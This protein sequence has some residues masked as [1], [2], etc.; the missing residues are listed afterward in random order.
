MLN[1]KP[2]IMVNLHS[3]D[4]AVIRSPKKRRGPKPK[5]IYERILSQRELKPIRKTERTYSQSQK[6]RVLIFLEH[7]RI[8]CRLLGEYRRPTQQEASDLYQIPTRTISRWVGL[9]S[10]IEGLG[11]DSSVRKDAGL[12]NTGR[13]LWPELEEQLYRDFIERRREGRIVRQG[14]F[15][16]QSQ[17]RFREI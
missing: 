5:P 4:M 13:I 10:K 16:I 6:L 12:G 8:P 15:R 14:W 9:R 17:F 11:R 1:W 7:H 3:T 2:N